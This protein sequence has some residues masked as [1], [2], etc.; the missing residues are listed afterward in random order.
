MGVFVGNGVCRKRY[1]GAKMIEL[2]GI[3]TPINITERELKE[4]CAK[5]AKIGVNAIKYFKV[6]R[7][8]IQRPLID[9]RRKI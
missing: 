2:N 6:V 8:S 5:K 7:R 3:K 9:E 1:R 4:K